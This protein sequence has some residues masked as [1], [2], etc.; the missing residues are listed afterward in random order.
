M[1]SDH[2]NKTYH[3]WT[4]YKPTLKIIFCDL[5]VNRQQEDNLF[6]KSSKVVLN[7]EQYY[8]IYL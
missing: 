1:T 6:L 2:T 8:F 4:F 7:I 5:F 3:K